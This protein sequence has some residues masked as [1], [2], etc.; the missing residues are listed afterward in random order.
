[1]RS[2]TPPPFAC[3]GRQTTLPPR[4]RRHHG[5]TPRVVDPGASERNDRRSRRSVRPPLQAGGR[6]L[7]RRCR[8]DQLLKRCIPPAKTVA[9][10]N[11][12]PARHLRRRQPQDV[13]Q[14]EYLP[15]KGLEA[16]EPAPQHEALIQ[17]VQEAWPEHLVPAVVTR[18][19][20][21]L[22]ERRRGWQVPITRSL[23][24]TAYFFRRLQHP[25]HP[26]CTLGGEGVPREIGNSL[27]VCRVFL[28]RSSKRQERTWSYEVRNAPT[29]AGSATERPSRART[30]MGALRRAPAPFPLKATNPAARPVEIRRPAHGKGE[31]GVVVKG[32]NSGSVESPCRGTCPCDPP[33]QMWERRGDG[34]VTGVPEDTLNVGWA[35]GR[36][37]WPRGSGSPLVLGT[38]PPRTTWRIILPPVADTAGRRTGCSSPRPRWGRAA[39]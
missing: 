29:S 35:S 3:V 8:R 25:T 18:W 15:I 1:V 10:G 26:G 4:A 22:D 2:R 27:H 14:D 11:S 28:E 33:D 39:L 13:Q 30:E 6:A 5:E 24:A 7:P 12:H 20:P 9:P 36:R 37:G 16:A 17:A 32:P 38:S 31:Q 19:R 23:E 34:C 21:N